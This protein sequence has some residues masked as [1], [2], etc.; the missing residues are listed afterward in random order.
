MMRRNTVTYQTAADFASS[1]TCSFIRLNDTFRKTMLQAARKLTD[2]GKQLLPRALI[3]N[4]IV[5]YETKRINGKLYVGEGG[6]GK[7]VKSIKN[8][9][10][11]CLFVF[12]L[13]QLVGVFFVLKTEKNGQLNKPQIRLLLKNPGGTLIFANP[14]RHIFRSKLNAEIMYS[15]QCTLIAQQPCRKSGF[16]IGVQGTVN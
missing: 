6:V 14:D 3:S 10:V 1:E 12:C 5:F 2:H 7:Y 8:T 16:K 9:C 4:V 13:L 11:F 15:L